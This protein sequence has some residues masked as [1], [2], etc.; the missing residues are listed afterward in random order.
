MNP[1]LQTCVNIEMRIGSIYR[2]LTELP[3]ASDELKDIWREMAEDEARHAHRIRLVADRLEIAGVTD[4]GLSLEQMQALY[5]RASEIYERVIEDA[6]SVTEAVYASVELEDEFLK[7][8]LNYAEVGGQPDLQT[9]FKL[10]AE[11]DRQHTARLRAYLD[12]QDDGAGLV[13][14]DPL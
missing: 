11:E 8:H 5:D 3:D 4:H 13:F 10:L 2:E 1:V 14:E 6:L 7:A 9:L 12:Q